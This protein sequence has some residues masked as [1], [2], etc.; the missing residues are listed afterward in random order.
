MSPL[1][2]SRFP[3]KTIVDVPD[4]IAFAHWCFERES[5]GGLRSCDPVLD[6][7][8]ESCRTAN[9]ASVARFRPPNRSQSCE[10]APR[11]SPAVPQLKA[12]QSWEFA[13]PA[14]PCP[15]CLRLQ[16]SQPRLSAQPGQTVTWAP[17]QRP[18]ATPAL[19]ILSKSLSSSE[20]LDFAGRSYVSA[21]KVPTFTSRS[22]SMY[23]LRA[24][25]ERNLGHRKTRERRWLTNTNCQMAK[26]KL[27][28]FAFE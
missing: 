7:L 26:Y 25:F 6:P 2:V 15:F 10:V 4:L 1:S 13:I 5:S 18:A 14:P 20:W 12:S 8:R 24:I 28:F 11:S 17:R 22:R 16:R 3:R 21:A 9:N 27:Q 19:G 23:A